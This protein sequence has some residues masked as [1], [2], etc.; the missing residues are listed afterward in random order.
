MSVATWSFWVTEA[1]IYN[2]LLFFA[3]ILLRPDLR[4]VQQLQIV[5]IVSG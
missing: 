4:K 2:D 3:P 5:I 1:V